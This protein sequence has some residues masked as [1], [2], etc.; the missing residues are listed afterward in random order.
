MYSP[1]TS[2]AIKVL[3]PNV[4][5]R[6]MRAVMVLL[7]PRPGSPKISTLGLVV[8]PRSTHSTGWQ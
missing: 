6:R 1:L 8:M 2:P 4:I 3:V 5:I 7:L